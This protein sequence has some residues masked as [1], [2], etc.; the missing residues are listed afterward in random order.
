MRKK[1]EKRLK[2]MNFQF[3]H[4]YLKILR[5]VRIILRGRTTVWPWLLETLMEIYCESPPPP[6]EVLSMEWNCL[7]NKLQIHRLIWG[8]KGAPLYT[9]RLFF[10]QND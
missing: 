2:Y 4:A 8:L 1:T 9:P 5:K 10:A 7:Y 3:V 6:V